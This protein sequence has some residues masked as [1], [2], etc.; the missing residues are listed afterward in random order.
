MKQVGVEP[1]TAAV[2]VTLLTFAAVHRAAACRR[3]AI[4]CYLLLAGPTAANLLH[5]AAAVDS[6]D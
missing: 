1:S 3:R 4:D 5:T 2:N 6:W